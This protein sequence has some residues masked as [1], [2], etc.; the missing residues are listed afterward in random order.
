M[1]VGTGYW[2]TSWSDLSGSSPIH[3]PTMRGQMFPEGMMCNV[4]P[5]LHVLFLQTKLKRVTAKVWQ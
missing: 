4:F 2:V 5:I 3:F 1:L